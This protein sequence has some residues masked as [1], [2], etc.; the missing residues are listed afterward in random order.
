MINVSGIHGRLVSGSLTYRDNEC[1][2]GRSG[3]SAI[4]VDSTGKLIRTIKCD[5]R[6][7]CDRFEYHGIYDRESFGGAHACISSMAVKL[8]YCFVMG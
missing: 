3:I 8:K 1:C 6:E 7:F 4:R 5:E 2:N